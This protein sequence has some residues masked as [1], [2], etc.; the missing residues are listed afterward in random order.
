ELAPGGSGG[1]PGCERRMPRRPSGAEGAEADRTE[2]ATA[3]HGRRNRD[4]VTIRK[5]DPY[6]PRGYVDGPQTWASG[7]A[8]SSVPHLDFSV[9]ATR[10][11]TLVPDGSA[12]LRPRSCR[13][14]RL[15]R[16]ESPQFA[17]RWALA[18]LLLLGGHRVQAQVPTK[19]SADS[20]PD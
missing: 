15:M 18:A 19:P 5:F 2:A 11:L 12:R 13:Q 6:P 3:S 20:P 9:P 7:S 14:G 8:L 16:H 10:G 4:V 1:A 17:V